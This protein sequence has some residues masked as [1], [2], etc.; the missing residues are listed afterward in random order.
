MKLRRQSLTK[1][2]AE[3]VALQGLTFLVDD[4]K[5]LVHFLSLTGISPTELKSW[6]EAPAIQV[7]VLDH[8]LNDES[9]LLVF[10]AEAKIAPETIAPLRELLAGGADPGR[11]RK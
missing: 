1:D 5:R 9:L 2:D 6:A 3:A 4:A 8:L 7:A 11:R 10:A